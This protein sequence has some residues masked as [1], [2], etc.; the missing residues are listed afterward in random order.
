MLEHQWFFL[1]GK[2][3]VF[4]G[5]IEC[6]TTSPGPN[7]T[8]ICDT[9]QFFNNVS[10]Y[11]IQ[12]NTWSQPNITGTKPAARAFHRAVSHLDTYSMYIY[13][14]VIYSNISF[15]PFGDFWKFDVNTFTWT[16]I[17]AT[18]NPGLRIDPGFAIKESADDIYL[19]FG[20]DGVGSHPEDVCLN[21]LWK[22][23]IPN[24]NW[25][26]L[27]A[28]DIN[29]PNIPPVRY[30][31]K[32]DYNKENDV[33][34]MYGGDVFPDNRE[35]RYD[36]WSYSV[37]DNEWSF[38][39]N[40][41]M[42]PLFTG[43]SATHGDIFLL[44]TGEMRFGTQVQCIDPITGKKNNPVNDHYILQFTSEGATYNQVYPEPNILPAMQSAYT[45]NKRNFYIWGG[46]N[47]F[48]VSSGV[49]GQLD[50]RAITKYYPMIWTL[51]LPNSL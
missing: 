43:A 35:S 39:D 34:M 47:F 1:D 10:I 31:A 48:C 23:N 15:T 38:L 2:L 41:S 49:Q 27:I 6:V 51:R 22:Y 12:T 13:G 44:S 46:F 30:Q 19:A 20:L 36:T 3:I 24:N 26:Q 37:Q 18:P 42:I 29:N 33:I 17:T 7:G 16:Q 4:G 25:T 5:V 40:N 11:D 50:H 45:T 32:F 28:N 21:D 9:N 8:L 14:G